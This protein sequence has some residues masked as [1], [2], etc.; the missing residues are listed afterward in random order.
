MKSNY[1]EIQNGQ[2]K[3]FST[4]LAHF[5]LSICGVFVFV[6]FSFIWRPSHSLLGPWYQRSER[7]FC[8]VLKTKHTFWRFYKSQIEWCF[9]FDKIE[10][11]AASLSSEPKTS[12]IK[13]ERL[14]EKIFRE[15]EWKNSWNIEN[16]SKQVIVSFLSQNK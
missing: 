16:W 3:P 7:A 6:Y 15:N 13:S 9:W 10:A 11:T 5:F 4:A 2:F 1:L 12:E 8:S 14:N